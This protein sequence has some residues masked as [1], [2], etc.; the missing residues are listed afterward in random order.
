M[1][2][3]YTVFVFC[4]LFHLS[5]AAPQQLLSRISPDFL[6]NT[7]VR[8]HISC[9][10]LRPVPS[11]CWSRSMHVAGSFGEESGAGDIAFGEGIEEDT[12]D[13]FVAHVDEAKEA[14]GGFYRV[15]KDVRR[16][17][18]KFVV[19]EWMGPY[20]VPGWIGE[21]RTGAGIAVAS[22]SCIDCRDVVFLH[23]ESGDGVNKG[24][25]RVGFE[26]DPDGVV[27][28]GWSSWYEIPGGFGNCTGDS[29][30]TMGSIGMEDEMDDLIVVHLENW[31]GGV[32]GYYRIG[33]DIG[34]DGNVTNGWSDD[35]QV[36]GRFGKLSRGVGV[37]LL[38]TLKNGNL[39]IIVSH[40]DDRGGGK[41]MYFR[42]GQEVNK[43][44]SVVNGWSSVRKI[45]LGIGKSKR[46]GGIGAYKLGDG[47]DAIGVH[48]VINTKGVYDGY[49][50]FV[51]F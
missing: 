34:P 51:S 6:S 15:G 19:K 13:I 27:S 2:I 38:D 4:A 18:T 31:K 5:V 30:M 12:T 9:F 47:S 11:G 32:V 17:G 20:Q 22:I 50:R 35:I 29:A 7:V 8:D 14:N 37:D 44:G 46:G 43:T 3:H 16:V 1:S 48:Y 42:I 33:W 39:D 45:P 36:S 49:L 26:L 40:M 24:E 21:T 25:Y 28:G 41:W 10:I 23:T